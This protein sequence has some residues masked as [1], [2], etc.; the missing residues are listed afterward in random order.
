VPIVSAHF[1]SLSKAGLVPGAGAGSIVFSGCPFVCACV[2]KPL[3]S[4]NVWC[5]NEQRGHSAFAV[6]KATARP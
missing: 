5:S 4:S 3:T 6:P 1:R 2:Y